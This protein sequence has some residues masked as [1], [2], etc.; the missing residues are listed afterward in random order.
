M[1]TFRLILTL[2]VLALVATFTF[3]GDD[4]KA[5]TVTGKIVCA[6]CTLQKA[7]AKACQDV[8]VVDENG[9]KAEYYLVKNEVA[10]KYGH[11]CQGEKGAVVTGTVTEKDGKTWLAATKMEQPKG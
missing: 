2:A 6:K 1:K 5:V 7:D 8:L 3:A 9:A 11:V 10:E 4:A